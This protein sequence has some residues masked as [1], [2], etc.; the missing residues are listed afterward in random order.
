M[1]RSQHAV[2]LVPHTRQSVSDHY[3][4]T[5]EQKQAIQLSQTDRLSANCSQIRCQDDSKSLSMAFRRSFPP[6]CQL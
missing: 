2:L 5:E 4:V 3:K 6:S 1:L